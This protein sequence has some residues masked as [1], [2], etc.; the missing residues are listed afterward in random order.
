MTI[1]PFLLLIIL[2]SYLLDRYAKKRLIETDENTL[3]KVGLKDLFIIWAISTPLVL[4]V[5]FRSPETGVDTTQYISLFGYG[6]GYFQSRVENSGEYLFWG[7]YRLCYDISN[8]SFGLRLSFYICAEVAALIGLVA[9]YKLSRKYSC[10]I[11]C[12]IYLLVYYQEYFNIIRQIP[13]ISLIFLSYC[14]VIERKPLKYLACIG[15]AVGFHLSAF[16]ALIIYPIAIVVKNRRLGTL[17]YIII[18]LI[19]TGGAFLSPA[20]FDWV[21]GYMGISKYGDYAMDSSWSQGGW[22]GNFLL[23]LPIAIFL[24][25]AYKNTEYDET[26]YC[27]NEFRWL[28][29]ITMFFYA[30]LIARMYTNWAFRLGYYFELGLLMLSAQLCGDVRVIKQA[31]P[32]SRFG[33]NALL[34]VGYYIIYFIYLNCINNLQTSALTNYTFIL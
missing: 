14:Y 19:L 28:I 34:I 32:N 16:V 25:F 1:F 27:K 29:V 21:V 15:L 17:S 18:C 12:L 30:L 22:I 20:L 26:P 31:L 24:L 7:I 23:F 10:G 5:T 11:I 2:T 8:G 9:I 33:L 4:L 13:A 6:P 3:L